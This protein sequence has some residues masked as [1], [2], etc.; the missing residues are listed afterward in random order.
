MFMQNN[1]LPSP[2]Q[3]WIFELCPKCAISISSEL[4]EVGTSRLSKRSSVRL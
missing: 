4:L 1:Y 2:N 3:N